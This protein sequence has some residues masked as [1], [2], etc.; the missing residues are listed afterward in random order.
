MLRG[1]VNSDLDLN[2]I[3]TFCLPVVQCSRLIWI[4]VTGIYGEIGER[5]ENIY[6]S[7]TALHPHTSGRLL[8]NRNMISIYLSVTGRY[9]AKPEHLLLFVSSTLCRLGVSKFVSRLVLNHTIK[10]PTR[11]R[12]IR[13]FCEPSAVQESCNRACRDSNTE[14]VTTVSTLFLLNTV[15][16]VLKL[17]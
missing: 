9:A 10:D 16:S 4:L 5:M 1:F 2:L 11:S 6:Q 3:G 14:T 12:V 13:R 7:F 15:H 17:P 8:T